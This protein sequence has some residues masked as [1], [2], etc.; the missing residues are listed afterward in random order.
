LLYFEAD[1]LGIGYRVR[2]EHWTLGAA[3]VPGFANMT[4]GGSIATPSVVTNA[5]GL[6]TTFILRLD[7]DACIGRN[8]QGRTHQS[9]W[10]CGFVAPALYEFGGFN[11]LSAGLRLDL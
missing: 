1:I 6:V 8:A 7:V 4:V 3:L 2:G 5:G 10:L 9:M 11:G